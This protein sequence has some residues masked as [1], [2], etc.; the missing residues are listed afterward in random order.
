MSAQVLFHPQLTLVEAAR[1][2]GDMGGD[3]VCRVGRV[4]IR[5]AMRHNDAAMVAVEAENY[6]AALGHLR[7]AREA[8]FGGGQ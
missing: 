8:M 2:A 4:R 7:A 5:L 3:L 1:I 6:D